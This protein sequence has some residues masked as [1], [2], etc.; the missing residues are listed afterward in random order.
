MVKS[1]KLKDIIKELITTGL[2][3][4]EKFTK[5]ESSHSDI[6]NSIMNDSYVQLKPSNVCNGVG[7]FALR[8][9]PKNTILFTDVESD[10]NLISW[11]NLKYVDKQVLNYLNSMCNTSESGVYLNRTI[12][13]I[14]VSYY[15]NHSSEPN[16]FHDLVNDQYITI[17]DINAGEELLCT[18]R[19][20][21]IDWI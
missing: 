10:S 18:Y 3:K 11:D 6:V 1:I 5:D 15:V 13:N 12:N 2:N 4:F 21:E 19:K 16:L 8:M 17:V 7:V 9:I 20:N 14:N